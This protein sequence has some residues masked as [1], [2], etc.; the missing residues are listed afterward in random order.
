MYVDAIINDP[1]ISEKSKEQFEILRTSDE[2]NPKYKFDEEE[3]QIPTWAYI[4]L[5]LAAVA[6]TAGVVIYRRR[7]SGEL[8]QEAAEVFAY[9]AELLA[10]GDSIRKQSSIVTKDYVA[11]YNKMV[12]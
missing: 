2:F 8:L 5:V 1:I 12:S 7:V 10:A 9:T 11:F 4:L 6:I 3:V